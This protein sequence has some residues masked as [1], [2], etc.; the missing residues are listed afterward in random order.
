MRAFHCL[1]AGTLL[2]RNRRR[3]LVRVAGAL[4]PLGC[5]AL[6][7]GHVSGRKRITTIAVKLATLGV[8]SSQ[9]A[10]PIVR[11]RWITLAAFDVQIRPAG[12]AQS[13]A[14]VTA[15]REAGNVQ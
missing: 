10:P 5:S 15:D 1:A 3:D 13:P 8:E 2:N 11:R 4:F 7:N 14:I 6:R 9:R 12:R